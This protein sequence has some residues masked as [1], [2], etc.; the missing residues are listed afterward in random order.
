LETRKERLMRIAELQGEKLGEA[1]VREALEEVAEIKMRGTQLHLVEGK[2]CVIEDTYKTGVHQS[3]R[4]IDV[5]D[6]VRKALA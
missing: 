2:L 6:E 4:T 1:R 5:T 3:R